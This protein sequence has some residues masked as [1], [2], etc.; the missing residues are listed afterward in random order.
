MNKKFQQMAGLAIE[1]DQGASDQGVLAADWQL[2]AAGAADH[3][4]VKPYRLERL[5]G[6]G[7]R[8][9]VRGLE[10]HDGRY[11]DSC[12]RHYIENFGL[13]NGVVLAT[14]LGFWVSA[15]CR[16]KRRSFH[17]LQPEAAGF[18][19]D[20]VVAISVIAASQHAECPALQACL[21][22]ITEAQEFKA[23]EQASADFADG[24]I[25]AGQILRPETITNPLQHMA[26]PGVCGGLAN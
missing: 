21:F 10:Q 16:V 18:S 6:M 19:H 23:A 26:G 25:D 20:E 24:L 13:K 22:A 14:R 9:W 3:P 2:A 7:F 8:Y 4:L 11:F 17:T 1:T 5:V 12:S 15:L